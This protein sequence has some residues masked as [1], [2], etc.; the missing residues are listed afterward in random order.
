VYNNNSNFYSRNNT[1]PKT[2][3]LEAAGKATTAAWLEAAT[4]TTTAN[5]YT[6]TATVPGAATQLPS[7]Q[8]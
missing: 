3:A 8:L 4:S 5:T 2:D 1:T 6:T 7:L